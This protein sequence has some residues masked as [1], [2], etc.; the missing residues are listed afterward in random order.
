MTVFKA[1]NGSAPDSQYPHAARWYTHIA[2]YASQHGDLPGDASKS[3]D[4]Y[5]SSSEASTSTSAAKA[6]AAAAAEEEDDEVDLFGSD[7]DEVDEEA[8]KLKQE[9]LAQYAAKKAN[10]PKTTAKVGFSPCFL[11]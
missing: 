9:R 1:L 4:A 11:L 2:S 5:V 6:P 7:D 3:A 10:K 8:E